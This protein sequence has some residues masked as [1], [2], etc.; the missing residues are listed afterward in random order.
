MSYPEPGEASR[1]CEFCQFEFPEKLGRYGCP[2]C[3]AEG[4][5]LTDYYDRKAL[6]NAPMVAITGVMWVAGVAIMLLAAALDALELI[7]L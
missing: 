6:R 1:K 7:T 3:L 4:W 5:D 2:N